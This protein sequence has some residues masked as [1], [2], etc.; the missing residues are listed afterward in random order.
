MITP[1]EFQAY[2]FGYD[3]IGCAV[4]SREVFCFVAQEGYTRHS[5]WSGTDAPRQR[6]IPYIEARPKG[7]Q[8]SAANLTGFDGASIGLCPE[9]SKPHVVTTSVRGDVYVTGSGESYMERIESAVEG[10]PKRGA[11]LKLRPIGDHLYACGNGRTICR[12][13]GRGHWASL[14]SVVP[15]PGPSERDGFNALDGFSEEDIY[16]VGGDDD[17]WQFDGKTWQHCAFPSDL[18]LSAVCCAEDGSVYVGGVLGSVFK[19]RGTRWTK[20]CEGALSIPFKDM[21]WHEGRVWCTN[22]YG[23][24]TIEE[25]K[26]VPA[27]VSSEIKVCAGNLSAREGVLLLAG[28]GGAAFHRDGEWHVLFHSVRGS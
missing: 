21:V 26:C 4:R 2:L 5:N 6:F 1:A 15:E 12:R 18:P 8:W 3:I 27:D 9:S 19:G 14:R 23:L 11:I 20:I 24:W 28:H 13:E 17:V 16:A 25:D 10:G 22:D 7:R